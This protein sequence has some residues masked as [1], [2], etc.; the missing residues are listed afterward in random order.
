MITSKCKRYVS[1]KKQIELLSLEPTSEPESSPWDGLPLGSS[2]QNQN[3]K[4]ELHLP[5]KRLSIFSLFGRYFYQKSWLCS[6]VCFHAFRPP[7]GFWVNFG[8]ECEEIAADT[9]GMWTHELKQWS[10]DNLMWWLLLEATPS[11]VWNLSMK[12]CSRKV[13][14]WRSPNSRDISRSGFAKKRINLVNLLLT[15]SLKNEEVLHSR[16]KELDW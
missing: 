13:K 4:S 14:G 9:P 11:V 12:E 2:P 7:E 16:K 8:E 15:L 1:N 6:V 3:N 10:G 5:L